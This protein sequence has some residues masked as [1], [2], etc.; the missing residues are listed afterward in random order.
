MYL[1]TYS[2]LE[3]HPKLIMARN[4][5]RQSAGP[6]F[7]VDRKTGLPIV[8]EASKQIKMSTPL[9]DDEDTEDS[10]DTTR[11]EPYNHPCSTSSNGF[12]AFGKAAV[13]RPENESKDEKKARKQAVKAEKQV[14]YLYFVRTTIS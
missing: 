7:K 4:L 14:P 10:D 11:R 6:K 8:E 3:N 1:G 12:E 13:G 9:E 2:N 5:T